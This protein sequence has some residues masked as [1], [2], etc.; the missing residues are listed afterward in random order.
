M[1]TKEKILEAA[2]NEFIKN[3]YENTSLS[4]ITNH[5]GISTGAIYGL[6]KNK[7]DILDNLTR[8]IYPE[9]TEI[10]T[11]DP[12]VY[13]LEKGLERE[14]Y[15][16]MIQNTIETRVSMIAEYGYRHRTASLLVL[17]KGAQVTNININRQLVANNERIN[18]A[19]YK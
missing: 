7:A 6:F 3:G 4:T 13:D 16:S 10:L 2:K 11:L 17:S 14:E 12:T 9:V 5:A 15:Y 1:E 8:D 18:R 19:Y